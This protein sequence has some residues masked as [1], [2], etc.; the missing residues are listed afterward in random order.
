MLTP[1]VDKVSQLSNCH[2]DVH[3]HVTRSS[4]AIDTVNMSTITHSLGQGDAIPEKK[5]EDGLKLTV[6]SELDGKSELTT[7]FTN[8]SQERPN[9]SHLLGEFAEE[10]K[11]KSLVVG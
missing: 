10:K 5:L 6:D 1:L 7:L 9:I 8:L 11:G 2:L 3:Y 4:T